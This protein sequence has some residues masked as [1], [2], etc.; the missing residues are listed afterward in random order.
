[1]RPLTF[2]GFDVGRPALGADDGAAVV[3]GGGTPSV[4]VN[5]SCVSD[6][7][8]LGTKGTRLLHRVEGF[9]RR[10]AP[11]SAWS[12]RHVGAPSLPVPSFTLDEVPVV[13]AA[14]VVRRSYLR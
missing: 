11:W 8:L 13:A 10:S 9:C 1:M 14:V 7:I 2:S 12:I 5:A 6:H 3:C 4:V